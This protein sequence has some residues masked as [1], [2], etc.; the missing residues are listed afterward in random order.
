VKPT[1]ILSLSYLSIFGGGSAAQL[2]PQLHRLQCRALLLSPAFDELGNHKQPRARPPWD[3]SRSVGRSC[4]WQAKLAAAINPDGQGQ[5]A[6][7]LHSPMPIN[8]FNAFFHRTC[9]EERFHGIVHLVVVNTDAQFSLDLTTESA[10]RRALVPHRVVRKPRAGCRLN[11]RPP[12]GEGRE[13]E[14]A[15]MAGR[16]PSGI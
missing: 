16:K 8:L 1:T 3:R 2:G 4:E 15:R 12:T 13:A 7:W 9:V 6:A 11:P 14:G 10:E 5:G